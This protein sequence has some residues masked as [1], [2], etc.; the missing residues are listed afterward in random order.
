M[1]TLEAI[2]ADYL[3]PAAPGIVA[4]ILSLY[5]Y[6][7]QSRGARLAI[8][9]QYSIGV[10][11]TKRGEEKTK[12]FYITP[13]IMN[14]GTTIGTL[15]TLSLELI[16]DGTTIK[17]FTPLRRVEMSETEAF[18]R[19]QKDMKT[20][21]PLLPVYIKPHEGRSFIFE[22]TDHDGVVVP[23]GKEC[24]LRIKLVYDQNKQVERNFRVII[25]EEAY[26]AAGR[27]FIV[28][29]RLIETGSTTW[30]TI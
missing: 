6:W 25:T 28:W 26:N 7:V 23:I 13:N 8:G 2:I 10:I 17:E 18:E 24:T 27:G 15:H 5:N 4:V 12:L 30:A 21:A 16:V 20:Q 9:P 11:N 1:A 3:V 14:H 29:Q 19:Y 22:F